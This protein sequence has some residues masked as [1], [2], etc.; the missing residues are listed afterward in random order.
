MLERCGF[1]FEGYKENMPLP[2]KLEEIIKADETYS[3]LT[4]KF[5]LEN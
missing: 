3:E 2:E 4:A 1:K 5:I